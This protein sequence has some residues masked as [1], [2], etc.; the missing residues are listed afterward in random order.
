MHVDDGLV[1]SNSKTLLT[2]IKTKLQSI[3]NLMWKEKPTL[4]LGIKIPH[5]HNA[6]TIHISQEHYLKTVLDKFDMTNF[7]S[8]PTPLPSN[9]QLVSGTDEKVLA[10]SH[11][12][13]QQARGCLNWAA[14]RTWPDIQYA[15]STLSRF[16]SIHTKNHWTALKDL[17]K[18]PKDVCLPELCFKIIK[19]I[20][21]N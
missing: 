14:V 2:D 13:Y 21:T 11:F 19:H 7:N 16:S 6:R 4:H 8:S 18:Y 10:S 15:V 1:L 9:L 3:Y 17:L 12:P 5:D 20:H